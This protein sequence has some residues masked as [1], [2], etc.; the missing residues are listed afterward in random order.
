MFMY[1]SYRIVNARRPLHTV[2]ES[3]QTHWHTIHGNTYRMLNTRS[4]HTHVNTIF[5][6]AGLHACRLLTC[7]MCTSVNASI[8]IY[9]RGVMV[10][11][12]YTTHP[13]NDERKNCDDSARAQHTNQ[14]THTHARKCELHHEKRNNFVTRKL[15]GGSG[16]VTWFLHVMNALP[17]YCN[18]MKRRTRMPSELLSVRQF[19]IV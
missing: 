17:I 6:M 15:P 19:R 12:C 2:P 11:M 7:A 13:K 5:G 16:S 3:G 9:G 8:S 1:S 14:H 10:P 18:E 4:S